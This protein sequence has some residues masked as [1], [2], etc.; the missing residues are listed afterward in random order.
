MEVVR[1]V[2]PRLYGGRLAQKKLSWIQENN[3]HACAG[4]NRKGKNVSIMQSLTLSVSATL[5]PWCGPEA[6][7]QSGESVSAVTPTGASKSLPLALL[8]PK[9]GERG[10]FIRSHLPRWNIAVGPYRMQGLF[11][12]TKANIITATIQFQVLPLS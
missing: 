10:A 1:P 5:V 12:V 9:C 6:G 2:V 11:E 8:A 4:E 3:R 7:F